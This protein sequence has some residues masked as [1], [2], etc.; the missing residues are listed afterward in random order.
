MQI[1][2]FRNALG[3]IGKRDNRNDGG[4]REIGCI[5]FTAGSYSAIKDR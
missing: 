4:S 3:G 2:R 1:F 5:T